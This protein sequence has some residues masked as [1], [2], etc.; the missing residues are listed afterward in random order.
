MLLS[1]TPTQVS[2]YSYMSCWSGT[3]ILMLDKKKTRYR[4]SPTRGLPEGALTSTDAEVG[5]F[6]SVL[7]IKS[8]GLT[9][10]LFEF[11]LPRIPLLSSAVIRRK[12]SNYGESCNLNFPAIPPFSFL[13]IYKSKTVQAAVMFISTYLIT[14]KLVTE[15]WS[16]LPY[17]QE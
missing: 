16:T 4:P 1:L 3:V 6:E 9:I 15:C 7:K 14:Y 2:S 10:F 13:M 11:G 5:G 17:K 8:G 12:F